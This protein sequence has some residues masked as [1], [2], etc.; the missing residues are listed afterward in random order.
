MNV[1]N[2]LSATPNRQLGVTKEAGVELN[3]LDELRAEEKTG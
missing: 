1:R 2:A 3:G